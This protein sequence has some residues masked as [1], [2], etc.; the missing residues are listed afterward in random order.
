MSI[1]CDL[2]KVPTP[3]LASYCASKHA[4]EGFFGS[5][6]EELTMSNIDV[7]ITVCTVGNMGN[8]FIL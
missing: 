6:R 7:A 3:F 1:L 8:K 2:G 4:L 5:L